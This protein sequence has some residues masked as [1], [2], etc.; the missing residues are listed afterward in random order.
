MAGTP[1]CPDWLNQVTVLDIEGGVPVPVPVNGSGVAPPAFGQTYYPLGVTPHTIISIG[2]HAG[3]YIYS[4]DLF[5]GPPASGDSGDKLL[6]GLGGT[7]I[8]ADGP[9]I[10]SMLCVSIDANG[11]GCTSSGYLGPIL[12]SDDLVMFQPFTTAG[13]GTGMGVTVRWS[14]LD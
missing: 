4:W 7:T 3:I 13:Y 12:I 2:A 9:G 11:I 14:Y 6:V 5:T 1:D 10:F 8:V